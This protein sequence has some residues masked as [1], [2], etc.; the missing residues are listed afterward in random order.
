VIEPA[1]ATDVVRTEWTRFVDTLAAAGPEVWERPTRLA[2][3]TVEDLARHVHWGTT[4]EADGL[5][6]AASGSAG[7]AAG[8]PLEGPREEIVPALRRAVAGLVRC[9]EVLPRPVTGA[10]P[11]PYGELP[12][13]LALDVFVMEAALHGSDLADAVPGRGR[14]GD[15][16]P[17]EA[18]GSSATVMQAFWPAPHG[19][20]RRPAR[21]SGSPDRRCAWRRPSTERRGARPRV[22]RPSWWRAPTTPSSST[23]TAGCRSRRPT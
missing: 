6:L 22:S 16:L 15:S 1:T 13:A 23:P 5:A 20:P 10:V 8:A 3:W 12:M 14:G 18:R 4:L 7:P 2:G 19:P 11:M 21:R 9:L 17:P